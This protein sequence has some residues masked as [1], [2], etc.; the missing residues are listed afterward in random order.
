[1]ILLYTK[2]LSFSGA[3]KCFSVLFY[4]RLTPDFLFFSIYN[5]V[6]SPWE[7]KPGAL[8][9]WI[10]HSRTNSRKSKRCLSRRLVQLALPQ[11]VAGMKMLP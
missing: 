3:L 11:I 4:I 6:F 9:R 2:F 5:I 10:L 8:A 1:M 7:A